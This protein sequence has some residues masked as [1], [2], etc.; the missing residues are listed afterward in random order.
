MSNPRWRSENRESI[1]AGKSPENPGS[2]PKGS[3][4]TQTK[5][6]NLGAAGKRKGWDLGPE[7]NPWPSTPKGLDTKQVKP[8]T[9]KGGSHP[10]S[11]NHAKKQGWAL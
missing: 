7:S 8:S 6:F 1:G 3:A 5:G 2:M 11:G 9:P 10:N 4:G